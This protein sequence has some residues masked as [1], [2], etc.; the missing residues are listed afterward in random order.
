[1]AQNQSL[2]LYLD[3]ETVFQ[4][5]GCDRCLF[6]E[7][8]VSL[9]CTNK[10]AVRERGTN[11]PGVRHCSYWQPHYGHLTKEERATVGQEGYSV[12]SLLDKIKLILDAKF[13]V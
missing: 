13:W 1:M 11:I 10:E 12:P 9:W 8:A 7:G 3:G 6:L 4:R 5:K 2:P